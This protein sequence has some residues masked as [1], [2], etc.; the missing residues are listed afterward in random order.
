MS[1]SVSKKFAILLLILSSLFAALAT[2]QIYKWVDE[3][4]NVHF[5]DK[6]RDS[7]EA[8]EAKPVELGNSYHPPE[9]SAEELETYEKAQQAKR[10]RDSARRNA[11]QKDLVAAKEEKR[12]GKTQLCAAYAQD[13]EALS[14][15]KMVGGRL[16]GYYLTGE[17][18]KS[19]STAEQREIV[20]KLR[21][22][23]SA[24]GC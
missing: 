1:W 18:G 11:E 19:I 14:S 8:A 6:P 22:E 5:G 10:Q 13:I 7:T 3:D 17:D 16:Q 12:R 21:N 15:S 9:R 20:D 4:G 23:S 24:A 2:A